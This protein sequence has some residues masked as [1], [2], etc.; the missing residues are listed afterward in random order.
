[1]L[2]GTNGKGSSTIATLSQLLRQAGLRVGVLPLIWSLM[3]KSPLTAEP[4]QIKTCK[5]TWMLPAA[6]ASWTI[7]DVFQGLTEFEVTA[8]AY[9]YLL[10]RLDYVIMEVGMGDD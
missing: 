2:Q 9:D 6:P 4:F 5:P 1:M 8:I 7:K 10:T 3:T